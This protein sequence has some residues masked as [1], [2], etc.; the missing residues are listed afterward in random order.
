VID[1]KLENNILFLGWVN[2]EEL[3]AECTALIFPSIGLESFGLVITEAMSQAR[4]VIG[5]HRGPTA[6]LVEENKTGLLFDPLKEGDLA[7]KILK[8]A[9]NRKLAEDYGRQAA[10]KIKGFLS[11]EDIINKMLILYKEAQI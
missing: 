8:L 1:L 7:A 3:Y 4:A 10:E 5:S 11:N 9:D 2:P 6:W